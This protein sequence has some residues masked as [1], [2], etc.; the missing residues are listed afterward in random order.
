M[1]NFKV[2][3]RVRIIYAVPRWSEI[4]GLSATLLEYRPYE[5]TGDPAWRLVYGMAVAADL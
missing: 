1:A 5:V 3:Q 2:G 4:V